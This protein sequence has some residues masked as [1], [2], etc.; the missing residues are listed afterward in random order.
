MS[1]WVANDAKGT[2]AARVR[3]RAKEFEL[4]LMSTTLTR[5]QGWRISAPTTTRLVS[6]PTGSKVF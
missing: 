4:W 5:R 6:T 3:Q 1:L 2:D